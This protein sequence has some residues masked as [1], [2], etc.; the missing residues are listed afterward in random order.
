MILKLQDNTSSDS[1]LATWNIPLATTDSAGIM[2]DSDKT[3][4]N[5]VASG[6]Q[7]NVLESVKMK[8]TNSATSAT[9]LS[10][11]GKAVT[12]PSASTTSNGVVQLTS[13]LNSESESLAATAKAIKTI[14]D[15]ILALDYSSPAA[16]GTAI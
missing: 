9:E 6:A 7:V 10:I 16:S 15:K 8:S 4:L 5:A 3:K 11:S 2:S 12:I 1:D 13:N 14:N